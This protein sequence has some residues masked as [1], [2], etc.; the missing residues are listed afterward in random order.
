MITSHDDVDVFE[1]F[2]EE[3]KPDN[4]NCHLCDDLK[5]IST[6]V[7]RYNG[8]YIAFDGFQFVVLDNINEVEDRAKLHPSTSFIHIFHHVPI[9]GKKF[10]ATKSVLLD[11]FVVLALITVFIILPLITLFIILPHIVSMTITDLMFHQ[12][13]GVDC[14]TM[15][16]KYINLMLCE[17]PKYLASVIYTNG[18]IISLKCI[19]L[20]NDMNLNQFCIAI[21]TCFR[22]GLGIL[23]YWAMQIVGY[24]NAISH[25]IL[26]RMHM[27]GN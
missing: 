1:S 12:I 6:I 5:I 27:L 9:I 26:E 23:E 15:I 13:I 18:I 8:K 19:S 3:S 16:M 21:Y 7:H 25:A 17:A 14:G 22:D 10:D 4:H 24:I 20:C 2:L 11:I